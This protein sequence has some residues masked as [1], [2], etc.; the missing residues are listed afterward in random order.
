MSVKTSFVT[1]PNCGDIVRVLVKG[2][3]RPCHTY[4]RH[5]NAPRPSSAT[6]RDPMDAYPMDWRIQQAQV[7]ARQFYVL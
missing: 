4:R 2:E 1:C 3:C 5:R 6:R 7:K